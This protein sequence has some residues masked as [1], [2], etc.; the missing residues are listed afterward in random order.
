[1]NRRGLQMIN[2]IKQRSEGAPEHIT[3]E[4]NDNQPGKF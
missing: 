2:M 3:S 4:T 1:M